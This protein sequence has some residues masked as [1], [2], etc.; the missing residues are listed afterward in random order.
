MKDRE[1]QKTFVQLLN[2]RNKLF[3]SFVQTSKSEGKKSILLNWFDGALTSMKFWQKY[4]NL[5]S[6]VEWYEIMEMLHIYYMYTILYIT[7]TLYYIG[8]T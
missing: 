1:R 5:V 6:F 3:A 7:C 4:T 8:I 2:N